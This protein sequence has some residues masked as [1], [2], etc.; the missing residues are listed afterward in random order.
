MNIFIVRHAESD[1]NIHGKFCT[2][3]DGDLTPIGELQA[4]YCKNEL[5]HIKFEKVYT[6]HLLRAIK[7]AR[8]VGRT[9]QVLEFE[10]LGE[11]HGGDYEAKTWEE[12]DHIHPKFHIHMVNSLS[13]MSLPQGES[14]E[15]V[16][17]RLN[18]FIN[19]ELKVSEFKS[20]DNI[21][22]VS[23]GITLRIL[24][25]MLMNKADGGV[26]ALH[27]ADNTAITHIEL[28]KES[29]LH[30]LLSNEHLTKNGM[31]RADYETW[32]GKEYIDN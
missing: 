6:S 25:N 10:E 16:K 3:T 17:N 7:T 31:D 30:C 9:D 20:E 27:W 12:I 1:N 21:L 22:I 28:G 29:I 13:N 24:I 19:Q 11:M 15:D 23:H 26:N 5:A 32:S 2:Y 14:Y 18:R 8:I 4:Q